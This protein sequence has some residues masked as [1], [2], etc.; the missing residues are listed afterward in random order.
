M[1]KIR[2]IKS[3]L[4]ANSKIKIGKTWAN[5]SDGKMDQKIKTEVIKLYTQ[6]LK[7][8]YPALTF[9]EF[10]VTSNDYAIQQD[11]YKRIKFRYVQVYAY[12]IDKNGKCFTYSCLYT[13]NYAGGGTYSSVFSKWG[14]DN[15]E[16]VDCQ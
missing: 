16:E 4:L 2:I 5:I 13:Q 7:N 8:N 1:P 3:C 9:K 15:I 11:E 10:K 12:A 6:D 14:Y